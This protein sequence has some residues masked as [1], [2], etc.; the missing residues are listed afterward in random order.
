M[1]TDSG[2][3]LTPAAVQT[4]HGLGISIDGYALFRLINII[5]YALIGFVVFILLKFT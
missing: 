5:A 2:G 1:E 4:L 3:Q